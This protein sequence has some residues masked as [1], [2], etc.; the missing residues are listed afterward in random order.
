MWSATQCVAGSADC[1]ALLSISGILSAQLTG[2]DLGAC[3]GLTRLELQSAKVSANGI[4]DWCVPG[5]A[6]PASC[7]NMVSLT[8]LSIYVGE[9]E[10]YMDQFAIFPA[11]TCLELLHDQTSSLTGDVAGLSKLQMLTVTPIQPLDWPKWYCEELCFKLDW[12]K[13]TCLCS[14]RITGPVTFKSSVLQLTDLTNLKQLHLVSFL[15]SDDMTLEL[16]DMLHYMFASKWYQPGV[17]MI[18]EKSDKVMF[19]GE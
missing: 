16:V 11:L 18:V 1:A 12:E 19:L 9:R 13:L 17:D 5:T 15:S 6:P 4:S 8:N 7:V 2:I 10:V 14:L 3:T